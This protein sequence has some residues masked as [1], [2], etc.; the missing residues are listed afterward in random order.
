VKVGK[1]FLDLIFFDWFL[2]RRDLIGHGKLKNFAVGKRKT[3]LLGECMGL[4]AGFI[5]SDTE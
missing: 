4:K 5:V 3:G 2:L 1:L